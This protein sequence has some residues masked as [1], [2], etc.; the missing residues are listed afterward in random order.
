MPFMAWLYDNADVQVAEYVAD[1]VH[2]VF[3]ANS[4]FAEKASNRIQK[5]FNG[6]IEK[7]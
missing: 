7:V 3:E 1:S 5:E 4:A 2:V 6:K